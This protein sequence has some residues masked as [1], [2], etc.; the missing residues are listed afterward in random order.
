M[1]WA[2]PQPAL[3]QALDGLMVGGSIAAASK[4]G[5]P[6]Y[7]ENQ[8][9][10]TVAKW[11]LPDGNYVSVTSNAADGRIVYVEADWAGP[12]AQAQSD[13]TGFVYSITTLGEI[14]KTF[15]NNGFAFKAHAD[16]M[17]PQGLALFPCYR[18][19]AAAGVAAC[20]VTLVPKPEVPDIQAHPEQIGTRARL[21]SI[22]LGDMHYLD[23]LWGE[24]K[25]S[26]PANAPIAWR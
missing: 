5:T 24:E 14:R 7:T 1:V 3:A 26:D 15:G 16:A 17:L 19:A 11:N 25:M 10:Y 2:T 20:F 23:S 22:I 12:K 21:V 18:L 13:F 8:F 4:L 6:A 9:P